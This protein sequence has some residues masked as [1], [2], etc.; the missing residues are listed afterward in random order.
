MFKTRWLFP[1]ISILYLTIF[2]SHA[3]IV[4]KAI[5]GDGV[6]YYAWLRSVVIDRDIDFTNDYQLMGVSQPM[7]S[8]GLPGNKYSLGPGLL[9]LPALGWIYPLAGGTGYELPYHIG[10][11][12][13]SVLYAVTGLILLYRLLKRTFFPQTAAVTII[14]LALASHFLFYGAVDPINS[15]SLSFF[16]TALFLSFLLKRR[17]SWII[18][19]ATLG[20]VGLVRPPDL[21]LS[22]LLWPYLKR[23]RLLRLAIGFTL[24]FLP[25]MVAWQGLYH[26]FW[27]SPYLRG[28]E[29]FNFLKPHLLGVLFSAQNGLFLW[30]PLTILGLVGLLM[31][32]GRIWRIFLLATLLQLYLVASWSTWWQGASFSGRMLVSSLPLLAFGLATFFTR[33]GKYHLRPVYLLWAIVMPLSV[34]NTLLVIYF[35][36]TN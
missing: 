29:G 32:K 20:L 34:I 17:Q 18:I 4:K 35:L 28:E 33:L 31:A 15:H 8:L 26:K 21:I 2:L 6:F 22:L 11:G 5:Y 24:A 14:A 1:I 23:A 36:L 27:I 7:T 9:W 3:L 25:Q 16:T 30:T 10:I 13:T 12:V 19:G